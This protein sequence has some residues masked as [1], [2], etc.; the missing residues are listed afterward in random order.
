MTWT[1]EALLS[2]VTRSPERVAAQDRAGWLALFSGDAIVEDPVGAAPNHRPALGRFY[3]TFIAGNEI[4]FE[5][6]EDLTAGAEVVRDVVIHTR[7]STG[8]R[9]EV[10]AHLIYEIVVDDGAPRIRRLRAI[11][12]LRRRSAAAL[13]AGP[14]GLW[15]LC[16]VSLQMLRIQ[17]GAGVLGYSRGLMKGIFGRGRRAARGLA[18]AVGAGDLAGLEALFEASATIELPVGEAPLDLRGFLAKL[19]AGARLQV[20][21]VTAAGWLTSL[22]FVVE[23]GALAGA[24]GVAIL[25]FTPATRK[26]ARARFFLRPVPQ[27]R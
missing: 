21:Q 1:R 13:R 25:E 6:I 8:L 19:G 20:S 11:W 12:D 22:R 2:I 9:V 10:P 15:T 3:D 27:S 17:G 24:G 18:E 14:R 26:I 7:L 16:A 23:G 5:V 4:T